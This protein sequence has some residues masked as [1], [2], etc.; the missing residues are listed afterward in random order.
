MRHS[1]AL[2]VRPLL[3]V[4]VVGAAL[5]GCSDDA[6]PATATLTSADVVGEWSEPGADPAVGLE[7]MEDGT[8]TG[9]DGCNRLNGRWEIDDLTVEFDQVSST[10][11]A[12]EGVDTWLSA[13]DAATVS[14]D[15]L[16]V[17]D[18]N[19]VTIGTLEK[20]T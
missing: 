16:I 14:G 15:E 9:T 19:D 1:R 7:L 10:M 2:V 4:A 3:L 12:C 8:V 6:D 11:M 13:L 5:V 18:D 17:L 20:T